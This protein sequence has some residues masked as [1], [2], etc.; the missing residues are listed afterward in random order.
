M[1]CWKHN[2]EMQLSRHLNQSEEHLLCM[3][4]TC[5]KKKNLALRVE[6]RRVIIEWRIVWLCKLKHSWDCRLC[7]VKKC[8]RSCFQEKLSCVCE[9]GSKYNA[10]WSTGPFVSACA[11]QLN[12]AVCP[13]WPPVSSSV[14][15]GWKAGGPEDR[16]VSPKSTKVNQR[17]A[18]R[19]K[20]VRIGCKL[21]FS[22]KLLNDMAEFATIFLWIIKSSLRV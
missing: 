1:H 20:W 14:M 16:I 12:V 8:C 9:W 3:I 18:V 5:Y 2:M 15:R 7:T 6:H 17:N 21:M 11:Q 13:D 10:S 19:K 4:L 22:N